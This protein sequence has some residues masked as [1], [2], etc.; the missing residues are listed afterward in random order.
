MLNQQKIDQLG[1]IICPEISETEIRQAINTRVNQQTL[2]LRKNNPQNWFGSDWGEITAKMAA[3]RL[4]WRMS[5]F[6]R[7]LKKEGNNIAKTEQNN[8]AIVLLAGM[9]EKFRSKGLNIARG[10]RINNL[11][12]SWESK[13]KELGCDNSQTKNIIGCLGE[14]LITQDGFGKTLNISTLLK[15]LVDSTIQSKP[16]E[17]QVFRC[18]PQIDSKEEGIQIS[19]D[20]CFSVFME[21]GKRAKIDQ[22]ETL[23]GIKPILEIFK[24]HGVDINVRVVLIDIDW[25]VMDSKNLEDKVNLFEN[26]FKKIVSEIIP[27]A[28][29]IRLTQ[30]LRTSDL[31]EFLK[32]PEVTNILRNPNGI[33]SEKHFERLVDDIFS[34]V[35]TRT[36]P[37]WFKTRDHARLLAK[38]RLALEW[39]MGERLSKEP[40][41]IFIQRSK[42][43][44]AADTFLAGAKNVNCSPSM[45]F[46]WTN[47]V[48]EEI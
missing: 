21:N 20:T 46:F 12:N 14:I 33:V 42:T 16:I 40:N 2:S 10:E 34:R 27:E 47:R 32:L 28:R 43:T 29:I 4:G 24:S 1:N 26:N 45:L 31:N 18:P 19:T 17:I 5:D 30:L 13:A 41:T 37:D 9:R 11:I 6:K 39:V 35:K 3:D 36:L 48:I 23:K 25:F 38:R 8:A 44:A 15:L 7:I 22:K